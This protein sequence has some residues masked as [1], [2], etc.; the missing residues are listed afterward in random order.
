MK[1]RCNNLNLFLELYKNSQL[2]NCYSDLTYKNRS[3]FNSFKT[4]DDKKYLVYSHNLTPSYLNYSIDTKAYKFSKIKQTNEGFV[5][6]L[7]GVSSVQEYM[8]FHLSQNSRRT[9]RRARQRL[10]NS[11]DISYRTY[12]GYIPEKEYDKLLNALEVMLDK[13]MKQKKLEN[14]KS[15]E[16]KKIKEH[17]YNCFNKKKSTIFVIYDS[18]EPIGISLYYLVNKVVF[19]YIFSFDIDY[20]RFGLGHI[21]TFKQVEWCF[22]NDYEVMELGYGDHD[23][24]RKWC[25]KIYNF[26]HH[27]LYERNSVNGVIWGKIEYCKIFIKEFLKR[28]GLD[29]YLNML[30]QNKKYKNK[31]YQNNNVSEVSFNNLSETDENLI[32]TEIDWKS[33][34]F[35][36]IKRIVFDF[37]YKYREN[38]NDVKLF[39][40]DKQ[41][42]TFFIQGKKNKKK[43]ILS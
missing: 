40:V 30:K 1:N 27:I 42:E 15:A 29:T 23:Y 16:W 7:S 5:I 6:D 3:I 13:R 9:V 2:P 11:F 22:E 39:R 41:L 18:N 33:G 21:I 31:S 25:N 26:E 32:C 12:N 10:E 35:I 8:N 38:V 4:S 36:F 34:E 20:V 19:C 17:F 37:L 24:K 28:K 14:E 43:F